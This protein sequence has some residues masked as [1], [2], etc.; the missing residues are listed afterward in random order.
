M[1]RSR[2]RSPSSPP[3][4][5]GRRC[6]AVRGSAIHGR[7]VFALRKIRKGTSILEYKGRRTSWDEAI[8]RPDSDPKD[9]AHTLL[10]ELDDGTVIDARLGGNAARWIN[11]SCDP[12]C[13]TYEDDA[14]RVFIEARR[15]IRPGEELT[16]DYQLAIDGRLSKRE[17]AQYACHCGAANCRGSLLRS[18]RRS[19]SRGSPARSPRGCSSRR[20]RTARPARAAAGRRAGSCALPAAPRS[21][22]PHRHR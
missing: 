22:R 20:D 4:A 2:V 6:Y 3:S 13:A 16:Y 15:T 14:G 10:F 1:P 19:G 12:N 8:E 9:P 5:R 21:E 7:G 18:A 17:R 11:H